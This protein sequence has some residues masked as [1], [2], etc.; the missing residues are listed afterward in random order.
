MDK[1]VYEIHNTNGHVTAKAETE[2]KPIEVGDYQSFAVKPRFNR[3]KWLGW[4]SS[5]NHPKP[6]PMW[7]RIIKGGSNPNHPTSTC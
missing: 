7:S 2:D 6:S 4:G 5:P 3:L 1:I